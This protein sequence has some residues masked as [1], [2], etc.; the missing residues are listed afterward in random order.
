[1]LNYLHHG[2]PAY[3][4]IRTASIENNKLQHIKD[5]LK[6]RKSI[7]KCIVI[8]MSTFFYLHHIERILLQIKL[9]CTSSFAVCTKV[10]FSQ[11]HPVC[12]TGPTQHSRWLSLFPAM[13]QSRLGS[14]STLS[15]KR[16]RPK[17]KGGDRGWAEGQTAWAD[18]KFHSPRPQD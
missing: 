6:V 18:V 5:L 7:W 10:S 1:M 16:G 9:N 14:F 3:Q 8:I 11:T 13:P 12:I 15:Q 4:V 2:S 17:G